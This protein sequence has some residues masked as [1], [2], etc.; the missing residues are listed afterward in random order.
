MELE[1][2]RAGPDRVAELAD[3]HLGFHTYLEADAPDGGPYI[4]FMRADP[5]MSG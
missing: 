4:W 3:E 2:V 1:V 5:P